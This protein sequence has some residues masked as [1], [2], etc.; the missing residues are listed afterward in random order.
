MNTPAGT[1]PKDRPQAYPWLPI[2]T[3][4]QSF[5]NGEIMDGCRKVPIMTIGINP[6]LTAF[7]PGVTGTSWAYPDFTSDGDTNEWIKYAYY[8][9]YRSVY[10]ERF[11]FDALT[12]PKQ[13]YLVPGSEIK[14][15]TRDDQRFYPTR[16]ISKGGLAFE[17][18]PVEGEADYREQN[19]SK[20]QHPLLFGFPH[21]Q[22]MR[23]HRSERI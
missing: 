7:S 15:F 16:D 22:C 2:T 11:Q 12:D 18:G 5:P 8:Y 20:H 19:H 13:G 10:Q 1:T 14:V 4:P 17:Y 23:T 21:G 3:R 6:N 9:R